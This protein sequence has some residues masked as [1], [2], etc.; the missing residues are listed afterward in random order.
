MT[1]KLS[2][3]PNP[4]PDPKPK[5]NPNP[6]PNPA[7]ALALTLA[8]ALALALALTL[9]LTLTR[10]ECSYLLGASGKYE[11]T[12]LLGGERIQG[13]PFK[14]AARMP[15]AVPHLCT[16]SGEGLRTARAGA[17]AA[18]CGAGSCHLV[19][20]LLVTSF[21]YAPCSGYRPYQVRARASWYWP[22]TRRASASSSAAMPSRRARSAHCLVRVR[23]RARA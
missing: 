21:C 9:A 13:S 10:Y 15:S 19:V 12:I 3:N 17:R 6:N 14:V 22:P 23:V 8:L 4:D 1:P 16:A 2:P 20:V 11:L 18:R 5:P 7:L